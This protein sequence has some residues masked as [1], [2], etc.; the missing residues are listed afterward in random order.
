MCHA[1]PQKEAQRQ[2]EHSQH[3]STSDPRWNP[4]ERMPDH[5]YT[6][7]PATCCLS[8]HLEFPREYSS[9]RRNWRRSLT[10]IE[11]MTIFE[12]ETDDGI[13]GAI[14]EL[15]EHQCP[16]G[17]GD[18]VLCVY[19]PN[20]S[21]THPAS[22]ARRQA[23]SRR[24]RG[25]TRVSPSTPTRPSEALR[26]IAPGVGLPLVVPGQLGAEAPGLPW[27]SSCSR[28]RG[29]RRRPRDG[30]GRV[31][32]VLRFGHSNGARR[33]KYKLCAVRRFGRASHKQ[34]RA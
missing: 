7:V 2:S 32:A 5:Q 13:T 23:L 9:P 11:S 20:A 15:D 22:T 21:P 1:S 25:S 16:P 27:D 3:Q 30:E 6:T 29:C 18:R 10:D 14:L 19:A 8:N 26:R 34:R 17:L 31:V 24:D 33:A 4:D 12:V 28:W